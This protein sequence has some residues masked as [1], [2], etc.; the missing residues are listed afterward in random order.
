MAE[1]ISRLAH[2]LESLSVRI[3]MANGYEIVQLET[4]AD[5]IA[6]EPETKQQIPLVKQRSGMSQF[7][8]TRHRSRPPKLEW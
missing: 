8:P 6:L 7:A 1:D 5:I 2:R 4:P 3:L